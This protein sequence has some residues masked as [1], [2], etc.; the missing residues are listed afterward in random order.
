MLERLLDR[1]DRHSGLLLDG[2][3][4]VVLQVVKVVADQGAKTSCDGVSGVS[5]SSRHSQVAHRDA[6][7]VEP[8]N[9]VADLFSLLPRGLAP[10]IT[11]HVVESQIFGEIAVVVEV[12]NDVFG[13]A[14]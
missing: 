10:E 12:V 3:Q 6:G 2:G 13:S 9:E 1:F 14:P 8:L 7:G 11:D 4:A 5:C